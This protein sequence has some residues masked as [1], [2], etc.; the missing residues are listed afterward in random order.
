MDELEQNYRD[1]VD[2]IR[3]DTATLDGY[4][5]LARYDFAHV[6]AMIYI[7]KYGNKVS[8]TD[9]FA[10]KEAIEQKLDDLLKR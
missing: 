2:F 1:K 5:E 7:D 4:C 10:G 8:T 9:S 3:F 6:P